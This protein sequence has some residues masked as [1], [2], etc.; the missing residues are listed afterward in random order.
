MYGLS[1]ANDIITKEKMY[2]LMVRIGVPDTDADICGDCWLEWNRECFIPSRA[3]ADILVNSGLDFRTKGMTPA[4]YLRYLDIMFGNPSN[5]SATLEELQLQ[6][7]VL[8][9]PIPN[10]RTYNPVDERNYFSMHRETNANKKVLDYVPTLNPAYS[11]NPLSDITVPES[12]LESM[13]GGQSADATYENLLRSSW[14]VP[15]SIANTAARLYSN[16]PPV[17]ENDP[18]T[19]MYEY[20]E[21]TEDSWRVLRLRPFIDFYAYVSGQ[22]VKK[23]IYETQTQD[24]E[25]V[26]GTRSVNGIKTLF[27]FM[28]LGNTL[29]NALNDP[30]QSLVCEDD[31]NRMFLDTDDPEFEYMLRVIGNLTRKLLEP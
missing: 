26:P 22:K 5:G 29:P 24:P 19:Y 7:I 2:N 15:Y 14:D 11:H 30:F 27:F 28:S 18:C 20:I 1:S 23:L 16:K 25:G 17:P 3:R 10:T 9:N 4:R 31:K 21:D 8:Q 6:L 13:L 12:T